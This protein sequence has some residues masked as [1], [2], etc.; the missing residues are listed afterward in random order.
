[1]KNI[2]NNAYI[3]LDGKNIAVL[4][5]NFKAFTQILHLNLLN[6]PQTRA[7]WNKLL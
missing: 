4:K 1:M 5:N 7:S 2:L 3:N 6:Y